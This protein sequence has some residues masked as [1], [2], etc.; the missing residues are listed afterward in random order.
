MAAH[1]KGQGR[2]DEPNTTDPFSS[3]YVD[4]AL[5]KRQRRRAQER[6]EGGGKGWV[7]LYLL[8]AF[9]ITVLVWLLFW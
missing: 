4:P 3:D 2:T 6:S 1:M 8:L 7:L 9:A 5:S